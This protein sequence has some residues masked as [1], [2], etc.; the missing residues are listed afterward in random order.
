MEIPEESH[1]R[2]RVGP[3]QT[4]PALTGLIE[5]MDDYD[6]IIFGITELVGIHTYAYRIIS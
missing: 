1:K 2:Y 3:K 4:R 5:N 6:M